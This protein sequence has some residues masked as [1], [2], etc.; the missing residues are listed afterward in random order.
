[1][2]DTVKIST[3]L[4]NANLNKEIKAPGRRSA[5]VFAKED[6]YCAHNYEPIPVALT[7]GKG[8]FF[9]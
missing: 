3:G 4:K 6:R 7:R 2:P 5:E 8:D 9:C 1:M